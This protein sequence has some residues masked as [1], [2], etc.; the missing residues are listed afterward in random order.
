MT[1]SHD[2]EQIKAE[3]R[4]EFPEW[5]IIHTRDTGRWWAMRGPLVREAMNEDASVDADTPDG[6][7]AKIREFRVTGKGDIR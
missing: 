6:L 1:T 5:S 7:R 4:E 3:L 2:I